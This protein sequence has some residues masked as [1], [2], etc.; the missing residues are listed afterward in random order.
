MGSVGNLH[1]YFI[2]LGFLATRVVV[3]D[4]QLQFVDLL[5]IPGLQVGDIPCIGALT[6]LTDMKRRVDFPDDVLSFRQPW[7]GPWLATCTPSRQLLWINFSHFVLPVGAL[8]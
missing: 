2:Q 5:R 1:P 8:F 7:R 3:L 4:Y 6:I